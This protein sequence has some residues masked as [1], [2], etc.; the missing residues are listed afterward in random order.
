M[1]CMA[2]SSQLEAAVRRI[3]AALPMA[4][5]RARRGGLGPPR[6]TRTRVQKPRRDTFSSNPDS[7]DHFPRVNPQLGQPRGKPQLRFSAYWAAWPERS[8][9]QARIHSRVWDD[10]DHTLPAANETRNIPAAA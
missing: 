7:S 4:C 9:R 5:W 1:D 6:A 10:L 2:L 3:A 8:R